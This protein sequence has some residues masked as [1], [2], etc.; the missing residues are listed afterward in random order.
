MGMANNPPPERDED[1]TAWTAWQEIARAKGFVC[2]MCGEVLAPE[3]LEF[4]FTET[5]A[6][7]DG[8]AISRN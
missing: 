7:C 8:L 6:D 2:T 3:E 5:C 1:L 4:G